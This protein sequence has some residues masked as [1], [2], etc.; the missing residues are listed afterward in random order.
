MGSALAGLIPAAIA[1]AFS[2]IPIIELI[3]VVFSHRARINGVVFLLTVAVPTFVIPLLGAT[4]VKSATDG[5]SG[6]GGAGAWVNLVF[7]VLLLLLAV[8]NL[9]KYHDTEAPKAFG[10]IEGM[11]PRAVFGLAIGVTLVNPK[12]L[13]LL[14]SAGETLR[15]ASLSTA[16][17][18]IAVAVFTLVAML[19][20]LAVIGYQ[21]LGAAGAAQ[22]LDAIKGALLRNNHKV[23]FWVCLVIGLVMG[24]RGISGLLS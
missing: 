5:G 15:E 16:G 24:A 4:V 17:M 11:G 20:Y 14:L 22:K 1:F 13:A 7:G 21:N 8:F 23:M 18:L 19:P 12:N 2:P 6:G 9:R 3:L 10:L